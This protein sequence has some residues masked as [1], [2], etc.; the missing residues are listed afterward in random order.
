LQEQETKDLKSNSSFLG[1]SKLQNKKEL[2]NTSS[3]ESVG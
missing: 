2:L 3:R 1:L